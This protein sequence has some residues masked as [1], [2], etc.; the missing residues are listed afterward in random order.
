MWIALAT[1][2]VAVVVVVLVVFQPQK[3]FLDDKVNE[4]VPTAS[5][6]ETAEPAVG[7]RPGDIAR[8]PDPVTL[9]RGTFI[10]R[11]HGTDGTAN[12][13]DVSGTAF[14]RIENLDTDNGPSLS[15]YLTATPAD[16]TEDTFDD[17]FVDLGRLKGN[18]GNQNYEIPGGTD[19]DRYQS[20]VIWCDRFDAAFGA[21]DLL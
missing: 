10:S 16:G 14:L 19:L 18:I 21:A 9:R 13:L 2:F 3:L 11:D 15:V 20:V 8:Q 4:A 5:G 7:A 6:A 1:A 12:V 17:D